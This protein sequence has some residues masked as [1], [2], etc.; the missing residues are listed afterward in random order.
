MEWW[1]TAARE[2][3]EVAERYAQL[4]LGLTDASLVALAARVGTTDVATF[5]ERHFRAVPPLRGGRAFR[6]LPGS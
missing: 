2:A 5:D 1:P 4:G 6:L 3:A